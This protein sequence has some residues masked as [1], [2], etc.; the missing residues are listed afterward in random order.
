MRVTVTSIGDEIFSLDVSEDLELEN[1]KA[2]CE[3]ESSIPAAEIVLLFQG[4]VLKD[5][6]KSLKDYGLRDGD[7]MVLQRKR[8]SANPSAAGRQTQ[9]Q[10]AAGKENLFV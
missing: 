10:A 7:V 4:N 8:A 1:F 5:N 2:F 9:P 6:G 3:I